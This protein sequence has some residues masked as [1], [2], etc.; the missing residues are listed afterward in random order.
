ML[1]Q[2]YWPDKTTF[3]QFED[4]FPQLDEFIEI[5]K[6]KRNWKEYKE[7]DKNKFL[8]E[9]RYFIFLFTFKTK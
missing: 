3:P 5:Q 6:E 9:N 1:S 2:C 4:V 8:F 7:N